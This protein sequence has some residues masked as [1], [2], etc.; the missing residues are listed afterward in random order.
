MFS[1]ISISCI[2]QNKKYFRQLMYNHVSPFIEIKGIHPIDQITASKTSHYVFKYNSS[3]KISEIINNHYHTEKVHPLASLGVYKVIFEYKEGK[4]IRT[5]YDPNNKRVSNDR[6]V[7]KEVFSLDQ[8]NTKKRLNFYDLDDIP[9]ESNWNITEYQW[10]KT[11]EY[12]VEKRY[13]L[14]S[15]LTDL[16]PYFEFGITGIQ[17]N[18]QGFPKGH[19][20]LDENLQPI[21]NDDGVAS[22]QDSYDTM[23][24]HIKYTYHD[25][26]DNLV[27][28]QWNY[29]IGNKIYDSI[30]NTIK[31]DLYDA[32]NNIISSRRIY[33]NAT[34]KVNN[35]ASKKDSLEIT[36]KALGYL[37]ALQKL[38]PELMNEVLNDSLN[39]IT[40]GYDRFER[41]QYG[42]ATTKKQMISFAKNWNKSGSRFPFNPKNQ[43][44]ILDIYNRIASVKLIS[45]NWVEY[46]Q[47]IKLDGKWEIMN[48]IWQYRDVKRYGD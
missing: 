32:D 17:I 43:I 3:N 23:G 18:K 45:D 2:A 1:L 24:N 36:Q 5:F 27:L 12:I 38:K 48:L 6:G 9:M 39:K 8:D 46:L 29:A 31:L 7:Y 19:Y 28:N 35:I 4:E 25:K 34:V 44:K 26:D 14:N 15:E 33:S 41:K 42:R 16:S 20:N 47:L 37:E 13:N 22:Y 11:K 40:I 21:N 10:L 30:G